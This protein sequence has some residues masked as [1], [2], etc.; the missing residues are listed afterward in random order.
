MGG[1]VFALVQ[2]SEFR[3]RRR[4]QVAAD[5]C[6]GFT[7]PAFARAISLICSLPDGT[8][9]AGFQA[10]G[11]EYQES[12]QLVGMSFET[13]GLLV[14]KDIASF[15][16][17]QELTGGLLLMMWRKLEGWVVETRVEQANPRFAE[18][19]QWLAERVRE[20]EAGMVPAFEAHR[21]WTPR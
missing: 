3:R 11:S 12:A 7:E 20:R 13:M 1:G 2:L 6:R 5:L 19:F 9:L 14:H 18:W 8:G 15:R 4:Y 21:G 17:V 10:R 16:I